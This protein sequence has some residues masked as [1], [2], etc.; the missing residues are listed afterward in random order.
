MELLQTANQQVGSP[1]IGGGGSPVQPFQV[2]KAGAQPG[3]NT[4]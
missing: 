1:R 4:A 3:M 2:T